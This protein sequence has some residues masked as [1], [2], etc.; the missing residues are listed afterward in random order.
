MRRSF[1]GVSTSIPCSGCRYECAE[2]VWKSEGS[3]SVS[4]CLCLTGDLPVVCLCVGQAGWL[5]S[6]WG[7]SWLHL[8]QQHRN[9]WITREYDS[10]YHQEQYSG[11][12]RCA[13]ELSHVHNTSGDNFTLIFWATGVLSRKSLHI[14]FHSP[15]ASSRFLGFQE[16]QWLYH[17]CN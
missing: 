2:R 14:F 7:Y 12:Q 9:I 15:Q 10:M 5:I 6:C 3:L 1:N 17:I 11:T 16:S 4:T 8:S 13:T